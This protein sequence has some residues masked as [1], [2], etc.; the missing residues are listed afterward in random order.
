MKDKLKTICYVF[1][2]DLNTHLTFIVSFFMI[3]SLCFFSCYNMVAKFLLSRLC[4]L[5][6]CFKFF[7]PNTQCLLW[8]LRLWWCLSPQKLFFCFHLPTRGRAGV[9]LGDAWYVSNVSIIF[10]APCLFIRHLLCVLLHFMAFLCIFGTNLLTRCHSASSLFSAIFVFQKSYT[11]NILGIGRNK[12]QTSYF[13]RSF[14]KTEDETEEA[15]SQPHHQGA[16]PSPWPRPRVVR[17]PGPI[18][19]DAPSPIKSPRREKPKGRIAF[20]QNILQA[21]AVVE[22]RSGG[23]RSSSRHP[24]G[25]GNPCRRPSPPPWSSPEACSS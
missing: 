10:D 4:L 24:T 17:P 1:L 3:F 25:E 6:P 21:A 7:D 8:W 22:P 5:C 19:D 14:V 9:K 20:P 13:Y 15:R 2:Y 11:W 12:S 23:S 18:S 16:R